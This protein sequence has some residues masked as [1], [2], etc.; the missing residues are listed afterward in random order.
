MKKILN[1]VL[2][3]M[4]FYMD[5]F[6]CLFLFSSK[7]YYE[8]IKSYGDY[9]NCLEIFIGTLLLTTVVANKKIYR[10]HKSIYNEKYMKSIGEL[11]KKER[12]KELKHV[13]KVNAISM[14][15]DSLFI[16]Y[17][18]ML[19]ITLWILTLLKINLR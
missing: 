6:N 17:V 15:L 8:L 5:M 14:A 10:E 3:F 18:Y 16:T 11:S 19:S 1:S 7:S 4:L 2:L 9:I 13:N 12:N